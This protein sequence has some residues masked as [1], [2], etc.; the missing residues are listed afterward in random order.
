MKS[1]ATRGDALSPTPVR[2]SVAFGV[3]GFSALTVQ[4]LLLRE[5]LVVWRGNEMSCGVALSLWLAF[6]ACG[7]LAS[8]RLSKR[9]RSGGPGFAA[10]MLLL[11]A[12]ALISVVTARG[13]AAI[14]GAAP[15]ESA[16]LTQLGAASALALAPFTVVSGW[17]FTYAVAEA[18]RSGAR[19]PRSVA[20]VYVTEAVGAAVAGLL[21]NFFLLGTL[22]PLRVASIAALA[23][24]AV[25]LWMTAAERERRGER[26]SSRSAPGRRALTATAACAL[27]PVAAVLV[28]PV[29]AAIDD[30]TVALRWRPLGYSGR[31]ESVY[32][33]II[34]TSSGTQKSIFQNGVLVASVPDRMAAEEAVHLT[35][36]QHPSPRSVLLL[37]GG[38][39]GALA[40][41]LKHP[42]VGAVDYVELDPELVAAAEQ[43]SGGRLAA[44]IDDPRVALHHTDARLFVKRPPRDYDAVIVAAPDPVSAQL[45]RFYTAEFFEELSSLL[46]PDGVVGIAVSSSENYVSREQA[47]LLACLRSTLSSVF[48]RVVALPGDPCHFVASDGPHPTR[49]AS[50]L[51]GR[52]ESRG[53]DVLHVRD[54]Y[55]RDRLS[56]LRAAALDAAMDREVSHVNTDLH[57]LCYFYGIVVWNRRTEDSPVRLLSAGESFGPAAV[58]AVALLLATV[59]SAPAVA[60]RCAPAAFRRSVV[61]SIVVVGAT[62]ISMEIAAIMAFQSLYGYVYQ[63]LALIVAAFMAGLALGGRLG[64][65]AARRGAGARTFVVLQAAITCVPPA[66][67]AALSALAGLEPELATLGASLVPL[68]VVCSAVLAGM[69]FPLAAGLLTRDGRP[70]AVAGGGLYGADLAGSAIGATLTAVLL[71]PVVGIV[72]SAATLAALNAAVFVALTVPAARAGMLARTSAHG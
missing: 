45:N 23:G 7:S 50:L 27:I 67:A 21:L 12:A 35:L 15:G 6:T 52:V 2:L 17:M 38:L 58:A 56:P 57:P 9:P 39:G 71:V 64:V 47:T 44:G 5:L 28:S 54:Y 65:A 8:A 22:E 72:G 29:G 33:R 3:L 51:A 63:K 31:T 59:F 16:T 41:I 53:L 25:S 55:L 4:V 1:A 61:L 13:A 43:V 70:A 46:S 62:E 18:S 30:A 48:S 26:R 60:R 37:G 36:L 10:G 34:T 42:G 24:A 14:F 69:Q 32:G 68:L 49:D 20:D 66:L 40:E 19:G 11:S